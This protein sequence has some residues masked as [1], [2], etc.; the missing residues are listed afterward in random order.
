MVAPL[1]ECWLGIPEA[2]GPQLCLKLG[3][4]AHAR[5]SSILEVGAG[6][7]EVPGHSY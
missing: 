2:L 5:N 6:G 3:V 7:T 4:V 1:T